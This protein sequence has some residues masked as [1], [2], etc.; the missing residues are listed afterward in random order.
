MKQERSFQQL[1]NTF[2]D[3]SLAITLP[4]TVEARSTPMNLWTLLP[5]LV[6]HIPTGV[7]S[8]V[9]KALFAA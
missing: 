2:I 3:I 1:Y 7:E 6:Q 8:A 9:H 5:S 4:S